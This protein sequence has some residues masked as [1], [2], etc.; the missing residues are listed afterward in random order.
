MN[1]DTAT[2]PTLSDAELVG[3]AITRRWPD[4]TWRAAPLLD[5]MTNRNFDVEV[6]PVD[7]PARR[8]VVQ[9]QLSEDAAAEIG[10]LRANQRAI[11]PE[12]TRLGL[13]PELLANYDDLG[14]TIVEYVEGIRL[15]DHADRELAVRL[16]AQALHRLHEHTRGDTSPGL[17]SDP[18]DG[19]RWLVARI[20]ASSTA[21]L[22]EFRW[23]LDIVAR[24]E[25]ARGPYEPCQVHTDA[26]HVNIF[27]VPAGDRVV[28]IDWEYIGAGDGYLD[29]AHFAARA[30]LTAAEEEL[31]V[32][33]YESAL[34]GRV[35]AIVR[36]YRFIS[37]LREGLWS[38]LADEIGF[39]DEF[40]HAQYARECLERMARTAASEDFTTALALLESTAPR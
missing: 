19:M 40:D 9:E 22:E 21:V 33:T 3:A 27:L 25:A 31:L 29:L 12:M 15:S 23:A 2:P 11:W 20:G 38:V 30:E 37:M 14:V 26:T 34:D 8:V 35:L 17:V 39:L 18:F 32:T 1:A 16:T 24:I 5:G 6:H 36:V 28:L 10:I 4:A 7:E 13:A